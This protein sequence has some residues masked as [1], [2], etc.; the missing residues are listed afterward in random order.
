MAINQA[1]TDLDKK[2]MLIVFNKS[3]LKDSKNKFKNWNSKIKSLK[4]FKQITISCKKKDSDNKILKKTTNLIYKKLVNIDSS[5]D[6]DY[7]FT[8]NR[9]LNV[10]NLY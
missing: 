10:W 2:E 8:E 9:Q 5:I 1:L 7:F 3:D 6:D 4:K